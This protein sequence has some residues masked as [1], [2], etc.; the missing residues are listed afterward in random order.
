MSEKM[1]ISLR[2]AITVINLKNYMF[3]IREVALQYPHADAVN[4]NTKSL[5]YN[6]LTN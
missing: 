6:V 4:T 5:V 3:P 2:Q 1:F